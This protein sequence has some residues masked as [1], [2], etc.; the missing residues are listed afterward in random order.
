MN[1]KNKDSPAENEQKMN[2]VA[3]KKDSGKARK[4]RD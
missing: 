1:E 4:G 2:G 3:E